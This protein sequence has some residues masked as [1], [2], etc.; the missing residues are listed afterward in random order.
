MGLWE[1]IKS[2]LARLSEPTVKNFIRWYFLPQGT[3]FPHDVWLRI[4]HQ[5]KKKKILKYTIGLWAYFRERHL[6]YK[7]GVHVNSNTEIGPGLKVVHADGVYINCNSI[8]KNFTIYQ[9]V[10]TGAAYEK[11]D[12]SNNG[13]PTIEDDVVIYAGAVVVGNI[14]LHKGCV[15]GANS[16][17]N[18]D[19]EAYTVVAG[20]PATTIK[21]LK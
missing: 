20:A 18:K 10:T 19:V 8:G 4:L 11:F 16:F 6:S 9:N 3:T 5:C 13:L 12:D 2:D 1:L 7:Y 14:T 17:V 21:K 15:I